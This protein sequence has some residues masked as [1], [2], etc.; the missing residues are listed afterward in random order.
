M[1]TRAFIW[2]SRSCRR[3]EL[4]MQS[5]AVAPTGSRRARGRVRDRACR[6]EAASAT[7]LPDSRAERFGH[8]R[9]IAERAPRPLPNQTHRNA[10]T[11]PKQREDRA[12]P[13]IAPDEIDL[14]SLRVIRQPDRWLCR[15]RL[16]SAD[17]RERSPYLGMRRN[18]NHEIDILGN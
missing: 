5:L 3:S 12:L 4:L 14:Q 16:I 9:A 15:G 13:R 10:S 1:A 11:A 7:R 17:S 8:R 2:R 6:A 18:G